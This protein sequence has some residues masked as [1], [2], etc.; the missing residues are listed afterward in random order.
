LANQL[1]NALPDLSI[2][3]S[4]GG[5][6]GGLSVAGAGAAAGGGGLVQNINVFV[7]ENAMPMPNVRDGR[8]AESIERQMEGILR[9]AVQR[10][11]VPGGV[12]GGG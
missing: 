8:D 7:G 11:A 6:L 10:A 1:Q 9:Q 4:L 2:A 5:S 12:P 3:A